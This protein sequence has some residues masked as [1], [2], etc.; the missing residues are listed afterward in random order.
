MDELNQMLLEKCESYLSY[1][2]RGKPAPVGEMLVQEQG[3]L[4]PL[5]GYPFDSCK[6]TSGRVDRFCTVR[7]DTN[8]Y[9]VPTAYCG[10]EVSVK[11]RPETVWIYCEG[12]CIARHLRC[13]DQH[14]AIYKLEYYLPLLEKKG[15]CCGMNPANELIHLY[16]KAT[17][18]SHLCGIAGDSA[19]G[20]TLCHIFLT[21]CW[22][23]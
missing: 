18:D 4:Y 15:R 10:K 6:R 12:K 22:N 20:R 13:L 8:S 7:F 11:A 2:I 16:A 5:P 1:Q 14:Q 19:A 23:L 17:E 3:E 9:S 21:C